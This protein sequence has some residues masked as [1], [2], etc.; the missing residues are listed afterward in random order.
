MST[1]GAS[2]FSLLPLS[3]MIATGA[4]TIY[5]EDNFGKLA[6]SDQL[7]TSGS[8]LVGNYGNAVTAMSAVTIAL[9]IMFILMFGWICIR[10]R[11]ERNR[12]AVADR[13]YQLF[14]LLSVIIGIASSSMNLYLTDHYTDIDGLSPDPDP[15]VVGQNYKLRGPYGTGVLAMSSISIGLAS[16]SM[17]WVV[18]WMI[19]NWNI[20]LRFDPHFDIK[21]KTL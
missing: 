6:K 11:H 3:S 16:V 10:S 20:M 17:T 5:M 8:M 1:Y 9:C 13:M 15:P 19:K 12:Q 4:I 21:Y 14:V 2:L 18:G 7:Q